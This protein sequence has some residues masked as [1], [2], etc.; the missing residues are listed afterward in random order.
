[1]GEGH[2]WEAI[3]SAGK[4][5]LGNLTAIIDQNG[6]Q[7]TGATKDVLD[8]KPFAEKIAP[9]GWH[10]QTIDGNNLDAVLAA[11]QAAGKVNDR[12]KL[13]VSQTQK[14]FGILPV[15]E[16]EGDLNYHGKPLSRELAEK[17]LKLLA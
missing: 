10:T 1:M 17:A 3:A 15:L 5:K 4:Y 16:A 12:P 7:Q 13:I 9:F 14:G 6:Y 11:L 8:L 2:V